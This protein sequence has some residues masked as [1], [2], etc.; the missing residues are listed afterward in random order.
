MGLLLRK[1]PWQIE[2]MYTKGSYED[3]L[4][5]FENHYSD[6]CQ[7]VVEDLHTRF[8]WSDMQ[9]FRDIIFLLAT[10]GWEKILKEDEVVNISEDD[11]VDDQSSLDAVE[12]LVNCFRIPLTSAGADITEVRQEF[13]SMVE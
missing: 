2:N 5:Y 7:L 10:Q 11:D 9:L 1:Y 6:I 3:A 13:I 4:S 12:S 8:R